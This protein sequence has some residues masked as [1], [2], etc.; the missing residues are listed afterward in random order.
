[1]RAQM[2]SPGAMFT[3][4]K[5][6]ITTDY[7][8]SNNRT[9]FLIGNNHLC[10]VLSARHNTGYNLRLTQLTLIVDDEVFFAEWNGTSLVN[11]V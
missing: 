6:N 1:M 11:V 9:I 5:M 10:F 2:L 4:P 3:R 8:M 7:S